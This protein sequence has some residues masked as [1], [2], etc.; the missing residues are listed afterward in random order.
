[1][2]RITPD[3]SGRL[4]SSRITFH[5]S[6]ITPD[7]SGRLTSSR[8]TRPALHNVTRQPVIWL[9]LALVL[10][11]TACLRWVRFSTFPPGLWYDE[12]YT[13]A[14]AQKLVQGGE[15]HVYYPEKHGAPAVFW[16][17][18]LALRLGAGHLAPRWV[19]SAS[20]VIDV[21]LLFFVVRDVMRR[22][23]E[24]ADWLAL[25]SAAALGIN[26]D[27]LFHS[28]M[29]WQGAL[30]STTFIVTVWFFWRGMR[31]GHYRDFLVAGAMA[32]ASQYTGVAARMLPLVILLILLG[33]MG[34]DRR[35]WR[36]RWKGLLAMGGAALVVFAPLGQAFLAH[37]SWFERRM[38]TAAPPSALLPN[39]GRTLAGWLWM[40]E[41][42]LHSL[43][44]RPIYDPAMG[45]L[46]LAGA[47]VAVWRIR[48]P[49]Y[50][51]WLAWFA[52]VL[53]GGFL[54]EPTPMFYRV[55]TAVPATAALCAVGGWAIWH[56]VA[57]RWPRGRKLALLLLA[58]LFAAST[59]ATCRDYFVRWANWPELPK[60]MDVWKWRAAESILDAP[61][62]EKLLVTIPYGLEPALSY[63]A[64]ARTGSPVRDF[65][66]AR[67][68]VY[69]TE[70]NHPIHYVVILGYEHRSLDRLRALFPSGQQATD[71]LFDGD[72][73][74]F[75]DYTIPPGTRIPVP[76]NLP[77]SIT[78]QDVV[79][80]GVHVAQ[81]TVSAGQS[82]TITLTWET[83]KPVSGNYVAFVHLLDGGPEAGQNPLK[84]QHDGLP[85]DGAEPTWRWQPGE[86]VLD[87]HVLTVPPDLPAGEYLLGVGLYDADTLQRLPPASKA[88]ETRWGEAIVGTITVIGK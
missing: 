63:A 59:W 88:L 78:Y 67:C 41:A 39:L 55:M 19:T 64:R 35:C 18:A 27:Y 31:D 56:L 58:L 49:A 53:P 68:M 38:Q 8:F 71:P 30:V 46:L 48:Q 34:K 66:G 2:S 85:C 42:A 21:L 86:Y 40:G 82:L 5:E 24:K 51:V 57:T 29:S 23:N 50:S 77:A 74:Y 28:R 16:L 72:A 26:Y 32:G 20:S 43:P 37:P 17:T 3:R 70:A 73:P 52:G 44:G 10:A 69:P 80:H 81:P 76:G 87:E 45:V 7:R 47:A 60:V 54:S 62:D 9:L 15:F 83:L 12:A 25:G 65:D 61:A 13:L 33:W 84:A 22:E 4:T 1:M 75:V 11:L 6:R 14:E 79:L 36:V